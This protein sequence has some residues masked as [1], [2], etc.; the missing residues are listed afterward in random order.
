MSPLLF[1]WLLFCPRESSLSIDVFFYVCMHISSLRRDLAPRLCHRHFPDQQRRRSGLCSFG[2]HLELSVWVLRYTI[3]DRFEMRPLHDVVL[4]TIQ[5]TSSP[6]VTVL[7][8]HAPVW[9][10]SGLIQKWH[11]HFAFQRSKWAVIAH[12]NSYVISVVTLTK[13]GQM[14]RNVLS[15]LVICTGQHSN[16]D[17]RSGMGRMF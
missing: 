4:I 1:G 5:L 17:K 10:L 14:H 6:V 13:S 15:C 2:I 9:L 3:I 16:G 12:G 11:T 7:P 8:S